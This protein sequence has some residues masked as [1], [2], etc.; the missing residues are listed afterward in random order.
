MAPIDEPKDAKPD[1]QQAG[2]Y[3]DLFLPFNKGHQQREGKDHNEHR[4]KVADRQRP[5]RCDEGAGTPF[6]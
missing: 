4:Q 2:P 5:K 3:L 1:D 6:H